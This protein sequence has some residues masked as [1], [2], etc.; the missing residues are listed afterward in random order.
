MIEEKYVTHV[1]VNMISK[2]NLM[3]YF[4]RTIGKDNIPEPIAVPAS[5]N[6]DPS[7]FLFIKH[8]KVKKTTPQKLLSKRHN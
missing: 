5:R 1:K 7:N 8:G 3:P 6:T 4:D 2:L